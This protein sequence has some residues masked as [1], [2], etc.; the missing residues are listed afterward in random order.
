M[1]M[2]ILSRLSLES[3]DRIEIIVITL[4][5][6]HTLFKKLSTKSNFMSFSE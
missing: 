1:N 4:Q 6:F 3:I 5:K 2:C